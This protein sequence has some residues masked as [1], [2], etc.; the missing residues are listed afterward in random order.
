[1]KKIAFIIFIISVSTLLIV[2]KTLQQHYALGYN[3]S[4]I[5]KMPYDFTL[6]YDQYK[7]YSINEDGFIQ[8]IAKDDLIEVENYKFK[9]KKIL[10]YGFN[11]QNF[12]VRILTNENRKYYI[13]LSIDDKRPKG[14]K[15]RYDIFKEIDKIKTHLKWY[16]LEDA[17]LYNDIFKILHG[18]LFLLIFFSFIYLLGKKNR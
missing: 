1:M 6:N 7:G 18:I 9:I 16:D 2:N 10:E 3:I 5:P 4:K 15:I 14:N 13:K 8:V 12:F 17:K 11:D